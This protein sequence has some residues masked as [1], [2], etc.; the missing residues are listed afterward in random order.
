MTLPV[1][2][3]DNAK[4]A[5]ALLAAESLRKAAA[6]RKRDVAV[7]VRV[8][9]VTLNAL[10]ASLLTDA[11]VIVGSPE[12]ALPQTA[13]RFTLEAVLADAGACLDQLWVR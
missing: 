12:G 2:I 13:R 8:E 7:E 11:T 9:G 3:G 5:Q 1:I 6:A 10:D 4:T